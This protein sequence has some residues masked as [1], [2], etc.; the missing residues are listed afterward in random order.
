MIKVIPVPA[1]TNTE[2]CENHIANA[3]IVPHVIILK[4]FIFADCRLITAK[5]TSKVTATSLEYCL[6]SA[7]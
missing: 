7:E 1:K 6:T 4:G 5:Y 2:G 3:P